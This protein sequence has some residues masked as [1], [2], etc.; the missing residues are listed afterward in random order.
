MI[1]GGRHKGSTAADGGQSWRQL[2]GR[3]KSRIS[4][5]QAQ[6]RRTLRFG[7]FAG[8]LL[9]LVALGLGVWRMADFLGSREGRLPVAPP[10][11][12][13]ERVYFQTDG[14]LPDSWVAE[15][16][17]LRP[18][19]TVMAADI[20]ALRDRLQAEGQVK[21]AAVERVF[22]DG[23]RIRVTEHEPVLRL[24]IEDSGGRRVQRIVARDGTVYTGRGYP[25]QTLGGLPFLQPYRHPDGRY[26]PLR[27]IERVAELLELARQRDPRGFGGWRVVS[28][29]HY[30]GVPDFP[31]EVIEVRSTR[32]PRLLFGA[33]ADFAVQLD[34]LDH[35][36]G[37]LGQQ[38]N[39]SI[40]RIDLSLRDSA[41]VQFSGGRAGTF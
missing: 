17:G 19:V 21:T 38:G 32:V 36:L 13:V 3:K 20:H 26:L 35:I 34:R 7:R 41:A 25:R 33:S 4:S 12:P 24:V 28:L 27:G 30:S 15:M 2:Q 16:T 29:E 39:P 31:G 23:L 14:V 6:R 18:G 9:V 8:I 5:R 1:G 11:H 22:P 37:Y 40:E 10:S